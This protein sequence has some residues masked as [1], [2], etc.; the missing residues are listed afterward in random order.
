MQEEV[1]TTPDNEKISQQTVCQME[2]KESSNTLDF[3]KI[4]NYIINSKIRML[5]ILIC[6]L[7]VFPD[8]LGKTT[9]WMYNDNSTT[10]GMH[11]SISTNLLIAAVTFLYV[12]LQ[13]LQPK[14]LELTNFFHCRKKELNQF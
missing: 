2:N 13:S 7:F 5:F 9:M 1:E 12:L 3:E 10:T 11:V 14:Q 4:T 8:I 6:I